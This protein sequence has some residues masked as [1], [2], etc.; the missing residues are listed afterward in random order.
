M[1]GVN[2]RPFAGELIDFP[3]PA[4]TNTIFQIKRCGVSEN[5]ARQNLAS[6]MRY[7]EK[8]DSGTLVTERDY[9][10]GNLNMA[11]VAYGL[12][13][14]NLL[15]DNNAPIPCTQENMQTYLSPTEFSAVLDKIIEVNPM[16]GRGGE[17]AAKKS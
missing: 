5:I 15:D 13:G 2:R 7:V 6:T 11:T 1:S 8:D 9:P 12:A 3:S 16:W 17:A 4:D 10:I 14:W